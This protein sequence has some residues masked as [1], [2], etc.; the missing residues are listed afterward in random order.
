MNESDEQVLWKFL[1][2]NLLGYARN[3]DGQFVGTGLLNPLVDRLGLITML[4][5][6]ARLYGQYDDLARWK[7]KMVANPFAPPVGSRPQ[8]RALKGL[9]RKYVLGRITPL[10]M[11]YAVTYRCQCRCAHCSA[12][13]FHRGDASELSTA[14]A[15]RLIDESLD[16]GICILA[17]TGGEPLLRQ[18]I[19]EL[20]AHVDQRKAMPIMFTNGQLLTPDAVERLADSG[21]YTLFLSLDAPSAE[22]HDR[23]RGIPGLFDSAI[24]GL[25]RIREK[26][27]LT[28]I[29]S[30]ASRTGTAA[31]AYRRMYAL[32]KR[33]GA[34]TMLLF[35]SVPTGRQLRETREMLT[36]EQREEILS[37]TREIFARKEIPS[38]SSQVWQNSL[39][40]YLGGIGCLAGNIQY[41]VTAYGDVTPCDFTPLS[42]GSVR[43]EELGRIWE[44]LV[45][46]PA[47]SHTSNVCRMQHP[48]FRRCF[49]EPIA[50]E[51]QLPYPIGDLPCVDYRFCPVARHGASL[52]PKTA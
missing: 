2:A 5:S 9:L 6:Q 16:L 39:E 20:I 18:D 36:E 17:F 14:E 22:E 7:G 12:A 37:F 21:L 27:V 43:E 49:I 8:F 4:V 50:E 28:G 26:G 25:E 34:H 52:A 48:G 29:S 44:R 45:A 1:G 33:I 51:A 40:G 32:A 42:F 13:R 35:D 24:E 30:Y 3:G 23:L 10:A 31:G 15:K 46:H 19:F 47:Y 11:T 38:L 41:Y